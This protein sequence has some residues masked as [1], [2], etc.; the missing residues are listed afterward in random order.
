MK[1]AVVFDSAGTLV[2]IMRAIKDL[3]KNKFICNRQT[4]DI[5]DEKNGRALVI[6]KENPLKVVDKEDPEKLISDLLKEVEIGISYCNPPINK[7]GIYKDRKTRVKELQDPLNLL[8]KYEVETGYGSA[9]IID[10]HAGEVEYTIATAGCLFPEVKETIKQLKDLGVKVFIAS[11]DRKGF[12]KR[13]AELT[14]VDEKY[15]MPEAHQEQKRDLVVNLKKEG[16]FTIMVGD[17]ANDVP[18]MIESDLAIATLQN[19]NVSKKALEAAD[20]KIYN[21]KEIVD[22][23]KKVINGEIKSKWQK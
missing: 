23:C 6:I 19:G 12:I 3:K 16:Y 17:G 1:L 9:L 18:A 14:G 20:I 8:K 2:K 4:V 13:L 22:V 7:E 15:I 11:G 10:T 5:V 21:I